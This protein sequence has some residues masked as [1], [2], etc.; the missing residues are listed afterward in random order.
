MAAYKSQAISDI[1]EQVGPNGRV[2]C[3]LS[4][5]VDSSVAAVLLH[6]AIGDRLTCV[7]VDHGL[8][9][10]GEAEEV[11]ALFGSLYNI[12]L[13]HKDASKLFL[14]K[15]ESVSD[16][17]QK[18]KI[19]GASFI[20]VFDEEAQKISELSFWRREPYTQM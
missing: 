1:K 10:K 4:G 15:L 3:G 6:K 19:I 2:I 13:I 9:R 14:S 12:P 17:E 11:V 16:P 18:R 5:G 7:F 8:L 20:D